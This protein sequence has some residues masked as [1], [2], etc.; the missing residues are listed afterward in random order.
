VVVCLE[1]GANDFACG[2]ADATATSLSL[3]LY[4]IQNGCREKEAVKQVSVL[5]ESN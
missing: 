3:A 5:K 2:P 1:R 4:K